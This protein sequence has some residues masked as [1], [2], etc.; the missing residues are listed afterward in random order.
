MAEHG[1]V[2]ANER[3][4]CAAGLVIAVGAA[5]AFGFSHVRDPLGF[6]AQH[7]YLPMAKRWLAEGWAFMRQP[8]SLI[9]GPVAYLYPA[10]LGADAD[11]VRVSNVLLYC[12][13]VL[14]GFHVGRRA[15]SWQAGL[16]CA[17]LLAFSPL[18]HPRS[19]E[20]TSELQ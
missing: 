9:A 15:H 1:A 4:A 10:M 14:L 17:L 16:A 5:R 13:T 6:D 7:T 3:A 12:A 11:A 2:T 19:E 18:L 20:H 8:E